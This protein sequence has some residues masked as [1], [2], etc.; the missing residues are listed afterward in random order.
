MPIAW[1][2]PGIRSGGDVNTPAAR[3][4]VMPRMQYIQHRYSPSNICFSLCP[5]PRQTPEQGSCVDMAEYQVKTLDGT[6]HSPGATLSASTPLPSRP[7][8]NAAASYKESVPPSGQAL[9]G[10]QE[11][12]ELQ[13][14]IHPTLLNIKTLSASCFHSKLI[15]RSPN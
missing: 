1:Q 14:G 9:T 13:C 6:I 8:L 11:H 4:E 3:A 7:K 5:F 12:C 2:F 15:S 10:K